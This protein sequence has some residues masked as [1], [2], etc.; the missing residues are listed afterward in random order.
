MAQSRSR[1]VSLKFI[2]CPY[3]LKIIPIRVPFLQREF[4]FMPYTFMSVYGKRYL[5][6]MTGAVLRLKNNIL[7]ASVWHT[8]YRRHSKLYVRTPALRRNFPHNIPRASGPLRRRE[9]YRRCT[10]GL[11]LFELFAGFRCLFMQSTLPRRPRPT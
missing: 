7:D 9:A 1:V 4:T 2:S 10:S 3:L 6:M 11:I 8:L 5:F